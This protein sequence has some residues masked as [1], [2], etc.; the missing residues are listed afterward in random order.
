M[1]QR[2]PNT[3]MAILNLDKYVRKD[4]DDDFFN[5]RPSRATSGAERLLVYEKSTPYCG[6]CV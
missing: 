1:Q 3:F 6:V 5:I 2:D 4:A